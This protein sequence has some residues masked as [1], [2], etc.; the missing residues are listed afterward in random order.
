MKVEIFFERM[1]NKI[2][3]RENRKTLTEAEI[4]VLIA[5]TKFTRDEII[6]WHKGFIV[7]KKC[8]FDAQI[9]ILFFFNS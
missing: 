7:R 9:V 3:G 2:A 6:E 1:G 4:N 5:N 8:I